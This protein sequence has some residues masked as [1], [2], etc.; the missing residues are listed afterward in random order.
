LIDLRAGNILTRN[1]D[2]FVEW[3]ILRLPLA[4]C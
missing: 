3:H 2:V 1:K 4:V